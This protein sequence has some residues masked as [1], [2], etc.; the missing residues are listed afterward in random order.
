MRDEVAPVK[1]PRAWP[2]SSDSTRFTGMA[3]QLTATK[4]FLAR[5]DPATSDKAHNIYPAWP[6]ELYAS[7]R[8]M[9]F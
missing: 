6:I 2:K 4:G 5:D 3:A 8:L 9:L 1:A 7:S